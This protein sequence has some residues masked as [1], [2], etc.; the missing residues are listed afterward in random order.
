MFIGYCKK[1]NVFKF[2][3]YEVVVLLV[4]KFGVKNVDFFFLDDLK[5]D[6]EIFVECF[7]KIFYE[8]FGLKSSKY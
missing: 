7:Y 6:W 2:N 5:M 1:L 3:F 8:I 4:E